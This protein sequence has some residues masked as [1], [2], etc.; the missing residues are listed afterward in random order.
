MNK[1]RSS[2]N[3]ERGRYARAAMDTQRGSKIA[4]DATLRAAVLQTVRARSLES[5]ESH[6]AFHTRLGQPSPVLI[7]SGAL[8]Y[9]RFKRK[10]GTLFIFAVDTSGSMALNRISQ[11]KGALSRLLQQS[12]VRRDRVALVSFRG[13]TA[14][15]LLS[16]SRSVARA[17]RMLDALPVGGATPLSAGVRSSV[18]IA[19][20]AAQDG[21][22]SVVLL[23]FTDGRGN[24]PLGSNEPLDKGKRQRLIEQELE[25]LGAALKATNVT[26]IV[27]DTQNRFVSNGEAQ[28]L[29]HK[30][31][32][33]YVSLSSGAMNTETQ[34]S[35]LARAVQ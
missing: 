18:E 1:G 19:K 22:Q 11:A 10:V 28:R 17:R 9:K 13:Q 24:V 2:Y 16:P 33:R 31:G 25:G 26:T 23:I 29:A 20:R 8:R 5:V 27:V 7:D 3:R 35:E 21:T 12:Y 6:K 4:L 14:D 15:V 30:L 32:G 34:Y